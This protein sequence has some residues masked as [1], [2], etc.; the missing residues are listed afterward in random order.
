M[1][2]LTPHPTWNKHHATKLEDYLTCPRYDLYKNIFGWRADERHNHKAFGSAWHDLQEIYL[3]RGYTPEALAE[4]M[5]RFITRY[6]QAFDPTTDELFAPK[7]PSTAITAA[8]HYLQEYMLKDA[9]QETLYT[10]ACGAIPIRHDRLIHFK[11]DSILR[12]SRGIFS[13][14]HKTGSR[15]GRQWIDKWQLSMQ[16]GTYS[17]VLYCLYPAD[18]VWGVEIN[19]TIFQKTQVQFVRV[20][21]RV[22]LP[23][24]NAWLYDVNSWID[25]RDHDL[26]VLMNDDTEDAPVMKAFPRNPLSCTDYYG[27]EFHA[28]C[29]AWPNPLQHFTEGPPLGYYQEYWDPEVTSQ[30]GE[31]LEEKRNLGVLNA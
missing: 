26:E 16:V 8:A 13:R 22:S 7:N 20:P 25:R 3:L 4:G 5:E 29:T 28:F 9:G 21:C 31:V 17:H 27:C 18:E 6:R 2:N 30:D 23:M 11:I 24:L 10:E 19:G 1:A 15:A 12:D 14:E